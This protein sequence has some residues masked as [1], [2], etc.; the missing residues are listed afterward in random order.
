MFEGS[1]CLNYLLDSSSGNNF[2]TLHGKFWEVNF[3]DVYQC[4]PLKGF[5]NL[6]FVTGEYVWKGSLSFHPFCRVKQNVPNVL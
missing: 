4:Y 1:D 2:F 5:V 3:Y 6:L